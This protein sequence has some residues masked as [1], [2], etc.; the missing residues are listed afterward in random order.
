MADRQREKHHLQTFRH[1]CRESGKGMRCDLFRQ[2]LLVSSI[3]HPE[4]ESEWW[5]EWESRL[6][7]LVEEVRPEVVNQTGPPFSAVARLADLFCGPLGF[8]G[9]RENYH[10]PANS[11]L[12]EVIPSRQGLPITL[13]VLLV[14]MGQRMGF[15][16]FGVGAPGHFLAGARVGDELR[17]ISPFDGPEL[18]TAEAAAEL[19]G[20]VTGMD[21]T[22][23]LSYLEPASLDQ[24]IVRML[25]NLKVSYAN[26]GDVARLLSTLDWLIEVEPVNWA[27]WRNRGLLLLR[28][29]K[30]HDGA[31][32]LL[33][34]VQNAP[35]SNE[36]LDLI[37][38]EALRAL[39]GS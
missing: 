3:H 25:N 28:M 20:Q 39:Q 36:D 5:L 29:G 37:K 19:V 21:R 31:K 10:D 38:T 17:F 33:H 30:T 12:T 34:Y 13:S 24:V 22:I 18:H 23:V 26:S 1:L 8:H 14:T 32:D 6:V 2:A 7:D 4:L 11:C 35:A 27:E 15:S 9:N 16:M